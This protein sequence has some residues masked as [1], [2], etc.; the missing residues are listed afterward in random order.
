MEEGYEAH[1]RYALPSDADRDRRLGRRLADRNDQRGAPECRM[2]DH[3]V[4]AIRVCDV[5][6]HDHRGVRNVPGDEDRPAQ[7]IHQR[8][9]GKC[10]VDVLAAGRR[11]DPGQRAEQPCR[12]HAIASP[13]S[14]EPGPGCAALKSFPDAG[15]ERLHAANGRWKF[16]RDEEGTRRLLRPRRVMRNGRPSALRRH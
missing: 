4:Q 9:P 12:K 3:P 8:I 15:R 1:H 5:E 10:T 7:R 13:M 16:A 14:N 11:R 6:P 2:N